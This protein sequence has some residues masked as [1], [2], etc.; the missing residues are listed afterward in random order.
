MTRNQAVREMQRRYPGYYISAD[1]C[2]WLFK[3]KSSSEIFKVYA[4]NPECAFAK[5]EGPTWQAAIDDC[6]EINNVP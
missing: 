5:G 6:K 4:G 1:C 2:F 3:P